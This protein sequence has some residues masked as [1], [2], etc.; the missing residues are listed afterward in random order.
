MKLNKIMPFA[1]SWVDVEI[2]M[3]SEDRKVEILYDIPYMGNL[4]I[5]DINELIYKI[6]GGSQT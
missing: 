2:V 6:E 5:N 4:N 3:L 1:A